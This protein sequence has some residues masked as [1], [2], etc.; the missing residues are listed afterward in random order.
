MQMAVYLLSMCVCVCVLG[1]VYITE[2]FLW[3]QIKFYMCV[4]G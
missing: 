3:I 2:D 4:Y 1:Y